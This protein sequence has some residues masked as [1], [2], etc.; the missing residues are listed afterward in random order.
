[1][2][3]DHNERGLKNKKKRKKKKT[4]EATVS[5]HQVSKRHQV[6]RHCMYTHKGIERKKGLVDIA[7]TR[8]Q[9]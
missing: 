2:A 8:T 5:T 6:S 7:C 4:K 9:E 3:I 1:M